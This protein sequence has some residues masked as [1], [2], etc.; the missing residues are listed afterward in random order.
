MRDLCCSALLLLGLLLGLFWL[1]GE[2]RRLGSRREGL[3]APDETA[4]G[5]ELMFWTL[6]GCMAGAGA[7]RARVSLAPEEGALVQ[8]DKER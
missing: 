3:A 2:P 4:H 8:I 5:P 6:P 1:K 7:Q